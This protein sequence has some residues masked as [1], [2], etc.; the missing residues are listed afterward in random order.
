MSKSEKLNPTKPYFDKS[1]TNVIKGVALIM[2]L[3]HHL[4]TFPEYWVEDVNYP[5]LREL[6]GLFQNQLKIC[7]PVFCF[8]TGYFYFFAKSKT[9]KYSLKKITDVLI[10]YW[11]VFAVFALAAVG[12]MNYK[13]SLKDVVLESVGLVRPTMF[14]CW[15]VY[16]YC[17]AMLLLPLVTKLMGKRLWSDLVIG[18]LLVPYPFSHIADFV[19]SSMLFEYLRG[20][21]SWFP[22]VLMGYIFAKHRLYERMNAKIKGF[23]SRVELEFLVFLLVVIIVPILRWYEPVS[24]IMFQKVPAFHINLDVVYVPVFVY[25][26][27]KLSRIITQKHIN[28]VVQAIGKQSLLMWF[29]SCIFYGNS[30]AFFQPILYL[31]KNPVLV[32]IWG[33]A[34]TYVMAIVFDFV[35]QKIINA[36]N[37]LF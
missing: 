7:V 27:I 28:A 29:V 19:Y 12:I 1:T 34:L 9:Y 10:N 30:K 18:I 24:A 26:I 35:V 4:F 32:T 5:L 2:M 20:I 33:L 37:K 17:T 22:V 21:S 3:V 11:V 15:Y 31:P 13:Y 16:F 6:S 14:F 36:K 25:G 8:L 23:I